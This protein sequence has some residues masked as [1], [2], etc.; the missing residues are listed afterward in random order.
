M[1]ASKTFGQIVMKLVFYKQWYTKR[2]KIQQYPFC[3]KNCVNFGIKLD[4]DISIWMQFRLDGFDFSAT[5]T[6]TMLPPS[7]PCLG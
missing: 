1:A 5:L 6:C 4:A 2:C 3:N 7:Y